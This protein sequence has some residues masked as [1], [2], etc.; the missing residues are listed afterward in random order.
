MTISSETRKS[1]VFIG[2]GVTKVFPFTFALFAAE[3]ADVYVSHDAV[4]DDLLVFNTDYT[5]TL[6]GD[7]NANP[8]GTVTLTVPLASG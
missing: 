2:D 5:V 7:Q 8:G 4:V 6:N 1:A 3:D